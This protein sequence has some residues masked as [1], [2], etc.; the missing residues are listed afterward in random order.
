MLHFW[1]NFDEEK[2][3]FIFYDSFYNVMTTSLRSEAEKNI[4]DRLMRI[5]L[6]V[7]DFDKSNKTLDTAPE[8]PHYH[9]MNSSRFTT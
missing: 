3:L 8:L 2:I 9:N 1:T 4:S 5:L 6:K 7:P